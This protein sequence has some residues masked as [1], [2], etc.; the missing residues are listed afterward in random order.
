MGDEIV[1]KPVTWEALDT[2]LWRVPPTFDYPLDKLEALE[3]R[4]S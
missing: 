2:S 4:I 1:L 3:S